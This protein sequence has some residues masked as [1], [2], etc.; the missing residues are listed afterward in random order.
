MT[1]TYHHYGTSLHNLTY[2]VAVEVA[3]ALDYGQPVLDDGGEHLDV[4]DDGNG[5]DDAQE[6]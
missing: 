4:A 5:D 2:C 6:P 3:G 1:Y